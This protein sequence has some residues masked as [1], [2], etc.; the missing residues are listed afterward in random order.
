[1]AARVKRAGRAANGEAPLGS[2]SARPR[3]EPAQRK[4][5]QVALGL[6]RRITSRKL[7]VGSL[8]PK[9]AELAAE[10][11]VNR[12]VIRAAVKLLEVHRL[13]S[14][15]RRRGT[16]VLEPLH[17]MSPEV[18]V[19]MLVPRAGHIDKKTLEAFLEIRGLLDVEMIALATE[20]RS[21]ADLK[22]MRARL[23]ELTELVD[24]A[25]AFARSVVEMAFVFA[26]AT[27]NPVFEMFAAFNGRVVRELEQCLVTTRPAPAE[28][29][30]GLSVIVDVI[31]QR[32]VESAR[33]IVAAFHAWSTPRI[34]A[35]AALAGGASLTQLL[36]KSR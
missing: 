5:D 31:E 30:E 15:V 16:E 34:L 22:A 25:P 24:D 1:M 7:P 17:S 13:L 3:G 8:L 20:R 23:A 12:G 35:S 9:E 10:F 33:R 32:D 21:A 14:P 26:R 19:A 4:A 27:K 28:H 2:T 6:L 29:V 11:G 36:E 18:L